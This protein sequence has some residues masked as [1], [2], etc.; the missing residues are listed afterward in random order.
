MYL[1]CFIN[2]HDTAFLLCTAEFRVSELDPEK[3]GL[4]NI[5][6]PQKC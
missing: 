5:E 6:H 2:A 1:L 4:F 3:K